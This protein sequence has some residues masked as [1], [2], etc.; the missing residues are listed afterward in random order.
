MVT[1]VGAAGGP[2][3]LALS[4]PPPPPPPHLTMTILSPKR[5]QIIGTVNFFQEVIAVIS[6]SLLIQPQRDRPIDGQEAVNYIFLCWHRCHDGTYSFHCLELRKI[7]RIETLGQSRSAKNYVS[8]MPPLKVH[9]LTL[10]PSFVPGSATSAG[11]PR[12]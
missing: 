7:T 5:R 8:H 10:V 12:A 2:P 9:P 4:P 6:L 1:A 11:S 3:L